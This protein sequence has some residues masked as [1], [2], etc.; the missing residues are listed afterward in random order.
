MDT[1]RSPRIAGAPKHSQL[2]T[3]PMLWTVILFF[4]VIQLI[5]MYIYTVIALY[6]LTCLCKVQYINV[7]LFILCSEILTVVQTLITK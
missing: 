1:T 2:E 7:Y 5:I 6:I 3:E 4:F